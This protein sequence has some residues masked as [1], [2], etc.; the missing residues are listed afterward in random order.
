MRSSSSLLTDIAGRIAVHARADMQTPVDHLLLSTVSESDSSPDYS[1]ASPM[2]VVM[3]Q[4]GKQLMVGDRVFEYRAGDCLVV[5]ANLPVTGHYID[6]A[7]GK[8]ALSLGLELRPSAVAALLLQ[9]PRQPPRA[10]GVSA[11]ATGA[12]DRDLLDAV[13]RMLRLLD[14]PE[15][16]AVM[17]PLIEQEILWR[18]LN[19]PLGETMR[20][21]GIADGDLIH[22]SRAIAWIRDHYAEPISI[23]HLARLAGMSPSTL[24][25][26]FRAV[27]AF[28]P[29]QFQKQIRLQHA[30][31]LLL[32]HPGDVASVGHAVGYDSPSQFTR[33]YHRVFGSPPARHAA[34]LRG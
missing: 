26:R 33:E 30:Q 10:S 9:M 19:G 7:P 11:V 21:I 16:I 32:A 28:S 6:V 5:T 34:Q 20:Q 31:S 24:H 4:G 25:R 18:A 22:I 8:P 23:D 12:A 17:A 27:T 13:A 15:D 29:I 3:A 14:R 1:L 2:L